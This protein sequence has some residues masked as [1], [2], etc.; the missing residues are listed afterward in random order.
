MS[1]ISSLSTQRTLRRAHKLHTRGDLQGALNCLTSANRKA[2]QAVYERAVVDLLLQSEPTNQY[3]SS[4]TAHSDGTGQR[5]DI[6]QGAIP[7]ISA[8]DF[9]VG[10]L[11]DAIRRS[12]HLIVRG[13]FDN[14][15]VTP[16]RSCIDQA[17]DAR[18][19]AG[20]DKLESESPWYYPSP[21]FPGEHAAYSARN[22]T[23]K[24]N[25]TGSMKVID[26]PRGSFRVLE[27]YRKYGLR[28]IVE[29]FF[30]EPAVL[31]TRK[32]VFRLVPPREVG[33][34]IGGGWHQDGQFMGEGVRALNMW[35]A[36]SECG[37]GTP[38]PGMTLL[39]KRIEEILEYGTRGAH[40]DWVVGGELVEELA[41]D[42]PVVNPYFA[43]GDALFFDHYSLHRSGHVRGQTENRYALESWFYA[44]SGTAENAVIELP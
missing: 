27:M 36:L 24:F 5:L 34:G 33:T 12:G 26:S 18:V 10:I 11:R 31:A 44:N 7:E 21:H 22:K 13:M 9:S 35:V 30:G 8:A 41:R 23:K 43:P 20:E 3:V 42:A 39:P 19:D 14:T 1:F 2:E 16:L 4:D 17:L 15:D 32:W 40:L 29:A 37:Q 6:R 25:R 28:Q 38:A